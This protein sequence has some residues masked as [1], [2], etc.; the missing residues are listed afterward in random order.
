MSGHAY[1]A[2]YGTLRQGEGASIRLG[3]ASKLQ[4]VSACKIAGVLVDLGA[5]PGLVVGE[6]VVIGELHEIGD[7]TAL[8]AL[9]AY[10]EYDPKRPVESL[11]VRQPAALIEPS[12][13]AFVYF[14]NEAARPF[15][16][17]RVIRSG[18]WKRRSS[19]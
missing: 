3:L 5:Y 13:T 15:D 19:D 1:L 2:L 7:E 16:R 12:L 10:E 11:F 18:D 17:A 9:D 14:F 4:F 6:G 8:A